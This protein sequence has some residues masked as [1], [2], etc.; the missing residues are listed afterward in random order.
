MNKF[1]AKAILA[2][3]VGVIVPGGAVYAQNTQGSSQVSASVIAVMQALQNVKPEA[4]ADA[5]QGL[6]SKYD[7]ASIATAAGALGFDQ[8]TVLNAISSDPAVKATLAAAYSNGAANAANYAIASA[9]GASSGN[10]SNQ[11]LASNQQTGFTGSN[12]SSFGGGGGGG[13]STTKPASGS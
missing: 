7:A 3:A 4:V 13:G 11:T 10:N 1:V 6:K 9:A 2:L 12:N 5:I 8:S